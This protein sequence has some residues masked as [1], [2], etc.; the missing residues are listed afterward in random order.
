MLA[1]FT[2][3]ER[4]DAS[5]SRPHRDLERWLRAERR[6][7]REDRMRVLHLS[8]EEKFWL[9]QPEHFFVPIQIELYKKYGKALEATDELLLTWMMPEQRKAWQTLKSRLPEAKGKVDRGVVLLDTAATPNQSFLLG[10]GSVTNKKSVVNLGFLQVLTG[11][12]SARDF[13]ARAKKRIGR[14]SKSE[15]ADDRVPG[16]TYQRAALAEWLTDVEQGAGGLLARVA[17][18]RMWQHHF[19]EGLSRT[20]D[21]FG[22]QG[23]K[24]VHPELLDWL[25]GE[26]VQGG[27]D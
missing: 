24:P 2:T 11:S 4:E 20:P 19:G 27:C 5:L 10:R 13:H 26:L 22:T 9:R 25:A 1:A 7:Y 3:A 15:H 16:T 17:V 23:E 8:D 12:A 18:N 14:S 21:D 6:L